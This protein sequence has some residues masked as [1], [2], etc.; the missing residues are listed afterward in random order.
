MIKTMI[1]IE[2]KELNSNYKNL[3]ILI[4]SDYNYKYVII[5]I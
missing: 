1:L 5:L 3:I 2:L 4:E